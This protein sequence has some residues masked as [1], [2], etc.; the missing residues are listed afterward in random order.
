MKT[1]LPRE[2]TKPC[3]ECSGGVRVFINGEYMRRERLEAHVTLYQA[4]QACRIGTS[5]LSRMELGQETFQR[6]YAQACEALYARRRRAGP[7]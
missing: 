5:Q 2:I 6:A 4:A 3:I 1:E 7:E